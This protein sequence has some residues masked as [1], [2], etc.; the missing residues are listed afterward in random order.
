M[1]ARSIEETWAERLLAREVRLVCAKSAMHAMV[2]LGLVLPG[3]RIVVCADSARPNIDEGLYSAYDVVF[4]EAS[5][6]EAF[7]AAS[8]DVHP[9]YEGEGPRLWWLVESLRGE[10]LRVPDLRGLGK[11]ARERG[12]LLAVDNTRA[13]CFGCNPLR[14]GAVLTF[15]RFDRFCDANPPRP[16]V[17]I[18]VAR[19]Q[20][21]RHRVDEAAR[22]AHTLLERCTAPAIEL[23]GEEA[24]ALD[25][26]LSEDASRIQTRFDHARAFAE[27]AAANEMIQNVE[28][29]GL[30]VHWD[31]RIATGVLEHGFGSCVCIEPAGPGAA[32][33][34]FR[35][36]GGVEGESL[37]LSGGATACAK[38]GESGQSLLIDA[39]EGSVFG[40]IDQV[41]SALRR[42][43]IG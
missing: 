36:L 27:Y 7:L 33:R 3:D 16:L 29:P 37:P 5:T 13:T 2:E 18:A 39:G 25:Q 34:L 42:V 30:S 1:D 31:H 19:S 43:C 20:L 24:A 14:L 32:L 40:L 22:C 26:A 17:A 6:V 15:E 8:G 12:A 10:G 21:K 23:S 9:S 4:V 41:D 38:L 11:A 35:E 28:Y